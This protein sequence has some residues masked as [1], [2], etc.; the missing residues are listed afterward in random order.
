MFIRCMLPLRCFFGVCLLRDGF[1][2]FRGI[3]FDF[4]PGLGLVIPGIFDMSC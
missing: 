2:F 4:G 3:T 1:L